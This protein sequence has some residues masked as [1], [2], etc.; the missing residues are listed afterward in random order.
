MQ[1]I[2]GM[3]DLISV[4]NALK[5][6]ANPAMPLHIHAFEKSSQTSNNDRR[7]EVL[8]TNR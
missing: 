6:P 7:Q 8:V 3:S 2:F 5:L 4:D 1:Q